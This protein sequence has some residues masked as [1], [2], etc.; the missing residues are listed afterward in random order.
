M[1]EREI[2]IGGEES[3]GIGLS[4][5]LPERDGIFVNLL[6]LDLLAAS[7]KT[8]TELIQDMW[9]EFGEFHFDRRD[10]HVPIE[11]G[12]GYRGRPGETIRQR[13]LRDVR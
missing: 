2:L 11:A 10:L 7:G 9:K 3:G 13:H 12:T 5:H 4:R 1:L 8:C 6:M